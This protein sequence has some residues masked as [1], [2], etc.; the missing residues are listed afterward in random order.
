M[1][2]LAYLNPFLVLFFYTNP[3]ILASEEMEVETI[4]M[5]YIECLDS[6]NFDEI[7]DYFYFDRNGWDRGPLRSK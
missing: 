6:K 1:K 2:Y 7:I 3:F 4:F 5:N